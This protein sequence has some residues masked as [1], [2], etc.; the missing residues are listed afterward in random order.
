MITTT[1]GSVSY[2]WTA[3]QFINAVSAQPDN[4]I[5]EINFVGHGNPGVQGIS[6]DPSVTEA[7]ELDPNGNPDLYGPSID[8]NPVPLADVLKN[9]MAKGGKI[10]LGGCQTGAKNPRDPD[11]PNIAQAVSQAVPGVDVTANAWTTVAD[12]PPDEYGS[13]PK[14]YEPFTSRSY[15]TTPF[16][17]SGNVPPSV[18]IQYNT[19]SIYIP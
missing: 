15:Y 8:N 1:D 5:S 2:V 6:D 19:P 7:L 13:R 16:S 10:N 12:I 4:S 18:N 3:N 11:K 9:K 14:Y 17:T